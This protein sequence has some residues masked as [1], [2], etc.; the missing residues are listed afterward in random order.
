MHGQ[1]KIKFT[2]R[3][4]FKNELTFL[5]SFQK[6]QKATISCSTSVPTGRI[7]EK[8]CIWGILKLCRENSV[9]IKIGQE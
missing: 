6:L 5:G 1:T 7:F 8:F 9:F 4:L 2:E 3:T